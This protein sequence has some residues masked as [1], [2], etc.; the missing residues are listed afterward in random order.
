MCFLNLVHIT[1][2]MTLEN[3]HVIVTYVRH[4]PYEQHTGLLSKRDYEKAIAVGEEIAKL[5]PKN[6]I[7][8]IYSSSLPRA[9]V[10][11]IGLN[12][13]F[14]SKE[15]RNETLPAINQ[16][17]E[18]QSVIK[19]LIRKAKIRLKPQLSIP[20]LKNVS[21]LETKPRPLKKRDLFEDKEAFFWQRI[22]FP[23]A[24]SK[25][26]SKDIEGSDKPVHLIM[27]SH[28]PPLEAFLKEIRAKHPEIDQP[29]IHT[30][31]SYSLEFKGS[32]V[33]LHYNGKKYTYPL[34][35]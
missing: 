13:G 28:Q 34:T 29:E 12:E 19:P 33:T 15:E 8:R 18:F 16:P 14:K 9:Q 2:N 10:T 7:R 21:E 26:A 25:S 20:N 32:N 3:R 30:L 35:R 24:L 31:Q 4:A 1:T 27:V 23:H 6:G 11:S 22:G 17:S 5:T